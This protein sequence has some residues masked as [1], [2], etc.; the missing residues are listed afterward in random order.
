LLGLTLLPP[1]CTG[2]PCE[3]KRE[4]LTIDLINGSELLRQWVDDPS[5]QP[6]DFDSLDEASWREECKS[7]LL[8]S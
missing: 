3:Y 2:W 8:Y 1:V 5:A 6:A 7:V 4:Q